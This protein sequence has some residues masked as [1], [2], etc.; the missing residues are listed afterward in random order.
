MATPFVAGSLGLLLA[1]DPGASPTQALAAIEATAGPEI[2]D[3]TGY[4][5][6]L[7]PRGRR[8]SDRDVDQAG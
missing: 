5:L 6:D 1:A 4:G 7:T 8:G 2:T 3:A